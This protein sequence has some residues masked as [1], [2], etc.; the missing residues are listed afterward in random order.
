MKINKQSELNFSSLA[1]LDESKP[2][3]KNV[4][5][6]PIISKRLFK[7]LESPDVIS[8]EEERRLSP[9][10]KSRNPNSDFDAN[11]R[12]TTKK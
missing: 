11:S 5:S 7:F 4:K 9:K 10:Y 1:F 8:D 12:N 3:R 2:N 6:P